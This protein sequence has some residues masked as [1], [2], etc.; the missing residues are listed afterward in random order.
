MIFNYLIHDIGLKRIIGRELAV[1]VYFKLKGFAHFFFPKLI[2]SNTFYV[3]YLNIHCDKNHEDQQICV[4]IPKPSLEFDI[5]TSRYPIVRKN[6]FREDVSSMYRL[7]NVVVHGG[8]QVVTHMGQVLRGIHP[9]RKPFKSISSNKSFDIK[10]FL[11]NPL[12][13]L[14]G[15]YAVVVSKNMEN[16]Y[17]FCFDFL[18]K[19]IEVVDRGF[20]KLLLPKNPFVIEVI[21]II[22]INDKVMFIEPRLNYEVPKSIIPSIYGVMA[23]SSYSKVSLLRKALKTN[24]LEANKK[25]YITRK[26]A[27]SRRILNESELTKRLES[28]NFDI[29][30]TSSL[31]IREQISLFSETN[32]IVSPHGAGLANIVFMS[33]G[34]YLLEIFPLNQVNDCYFELSTFSGINYDCIIGMDADK[35]DDFNVD[36]EFVT[37]KVN[38]YIESIEFR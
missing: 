20:D 14:D 1:L 34:S 28:L 37:N 23:L 35:Y 36:V 19:L 29:V 13:K 11:N 15:E 5:S 4:F 2:T 10:E 18:P 26:S 7:D 12:I 30:D 16:Y 22:G 9:E 38:Q 3:G 32:I 17:H 6:R 25:V 8:S 33:E 31:T 27:S 21:E 24:A